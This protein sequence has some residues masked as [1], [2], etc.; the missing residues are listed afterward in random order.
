METKERP[1]LS[2]LQAVVAYV[3]PCVE[4]YEQENFLVLL[5]N[6]KNR[7]LC[8][9]LLISRGTLDS[10]VVHPRDVF[11]EA[12]RQN[13]AAIIVIHNHPSGDVTPSK[14]DYVIT[15][16]LME[17][18]EILGIRMLDHLVVAECGGFYSLKSGS[19][20]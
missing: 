11:R 3:L 1:E 8:S 19:A 10:T 13:A 4:T 6:N 12:V 18:G 5:L 20:A 17:A 7:P 15:K 16:R 9:P 14:E 2:N